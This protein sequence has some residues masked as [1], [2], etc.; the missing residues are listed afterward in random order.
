MKNILLALVFAFVLISPLIK[1]DPDQLHLINSIPTT[2]GS[3]SCLQQKQYLQAQLRVANEQCNKAT[4][5][6]PNYGLFWCQKINETKSKIQALS[7]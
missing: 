2:I 1:A 4:T 5:E 3:F 6:N 7:C